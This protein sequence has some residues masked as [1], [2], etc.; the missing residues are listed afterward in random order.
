MTDDSEKFLYSNVRGNNITRKAQ[1]YAEKNHGKILVIR[2]KREIIFLF[3]FK[4]ILIFLSFSSNSC[5][6]AISEKTTDFK[7]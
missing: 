2:V 1:I 6:F 3:S 4:K 5:I 7:R